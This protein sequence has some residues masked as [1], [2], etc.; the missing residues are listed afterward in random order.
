[1]NPGKAYPLGAVYD[2]CL[3][4]EGGQALTEGGGAHAADLSQILDGNRPIEFFHGLEDSMAGVLAWRRAPERVCPRLAGFDRQ[5]QSRT[6]CTKL[7]GDIILARGGT[8]FDRQKQVGAASAK[9]QI[10]IAPS[11]QV[12]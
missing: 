3:I 9:I 12:A 2:P 6:V 5:S 7:D 8:V 4:F 1:M 11:V 10:A